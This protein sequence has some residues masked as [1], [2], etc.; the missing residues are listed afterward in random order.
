MHFQNTVLGKLDVVNLT[1][2][3]WFLVFIKAVFHPISSGLLSYCEHFSFLFMATF[4]GRKALQGLAAGIGLV[5]EASSVHKSKKQQSSSSAS[6]SST[7]D[8]VPR[9]TGVLLPGN[10]SDAGADTLEQQWILDE[11]QDEL[12]HSS[13]NPP[14]PPYSSSTESV[15]QNDLAQRFISSYPSPPSYST[16]ADIP[17]P[18]LSAPVI[19]PQRRPKNRERG[20]IRAYAPTLENC[21]IGQAMF[22]DFL[23][24][25]EKSCQANPWLSAINLASIGTMW[26]PSVTGIAVSIAIQIATDVAIAA[27]GRRK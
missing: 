21:G 20:F 6:S 23:N 15:D 1:E 3:V 10:N 16:Y 4:I 19:L 18:Q 9:G 2:Q 12:T 7:P 22:I 11:A 25:A 14:S 17:R 26:M 8:E 27:D 5:S 13:N 24:T